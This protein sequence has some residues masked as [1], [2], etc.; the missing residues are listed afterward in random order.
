MEM[1]NLPVEP[2]KD[3]DLVLM[4]GEIQHCPGHCAVVTRDG[5]V[6]WGYHTDNFQ[7]LSE[8]EV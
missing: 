3:G 2:F 5:L 7:R 8:D 4:L 6:R 1:H